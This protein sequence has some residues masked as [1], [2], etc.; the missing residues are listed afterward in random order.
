MDTLELWEI[1]RE[2]V[3]DVKCGIKKHIVN[4]VAK[5]EADTTS[6]NNTLYEVPN[7]ND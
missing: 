6:A 2:E 3:E 1:I 5:Y 4:D 7:G